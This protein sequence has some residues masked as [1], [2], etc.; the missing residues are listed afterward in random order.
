MR[1]VSLFSGAGGLD[2]GL[3]KSGHNVVWANDT[4]RDAVATYRANIGDEIQLGDIGGVVVSSIPKADA[5]VGGFPCQGFSQANMERWEGDERNTLFREFVRVVRGVQPRYFLAENVRGLLNL[6]GG[7]LREKILRCFRGAGYRVEYHLVNAA[8]YGVPQNRQRV[9]FLGTRNDLPST[10]DFRLPPP[11]HA[12]PRLAVGLRLKPWVSVG[13]VL[14]TIPDI[15]EE[16]VLR[17]HVCSQYKVAYRDFTGHRKTD[18]SKPSPT[19]LARGNGKGGVCAIPHPMFERRMSV[20][21]SALIQTFPRSFVF[22]GA[23]NS[24]YRQV[25]NAVPVLLAKQI[26]R[27]LAR[28]DRSDLR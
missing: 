2:Y 27:A 26:G 19:I 21:E 24:M 18:P 4:D 6:S 9:L 8:D 20:R 5:V 14:A 16:H 28:A 15:H 17:N 25:G 23:L 13:E 10:R 11:T 12:N 7:V 22:S 3:V 1:V